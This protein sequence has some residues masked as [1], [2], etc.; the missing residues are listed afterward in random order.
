MNIKFTLQRNKILR[1]D[2]FIQNIV[3][4]AEERF[5]RPG[6][7]ISKNSGRNYFI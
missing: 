3:R 4:G 2:I 5:N 7:L 6:I 1:H